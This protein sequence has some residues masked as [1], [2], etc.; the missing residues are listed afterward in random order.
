ML[1]HHPC[2]CTG[3]STNPSYCP[4]PKEIPSKE[5]KGTTDEKRGRDCPTSGLGE[6]MHKENKDVLKPYSGA[7]C[8]F[9]S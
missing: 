8:R 6:L 5:T 9:L 7:L 3:C 1:S 2:H 4:V